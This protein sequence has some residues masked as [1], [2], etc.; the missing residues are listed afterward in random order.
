MSRRV[1]MWKTV[2]EVGRMLMVA[3]FLPPVQA[4]ITVPNAIDKLHTQQVPLANDFLHAVGARR[5]DKE[6]GS[7]HHGRH[8]QVLELPCGT[9]LQPRETHTRHYHLQLLTIEE[10]RRR[11]SLLHVPARAD[12]SKRHARL[13]TTIRQI[14]RGRGAVGGRVQVPALE[15][16]RLQRGSSLVWWTR[17]G[18]GYTGQGVLHV[19]QACQPDAEETVLPRCHGGF[20]HKVLLGC[21]G[22]ATLQC[23]RVLQSPGRRAEEHGRSD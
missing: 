11:G 15:T 4:V 18:E 5:P 9:L 16:Y 10:C 7:A 20:R 8:C 21:A 13:D 12:L 14:R 2:L 1:T 23:A 3:A 22:T 19:D 6:R 17:G